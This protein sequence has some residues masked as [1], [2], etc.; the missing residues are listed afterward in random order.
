MIDLLIKATYVVE[1]AGL[2]GIPLGLYLL[3]KSGPEHP[4]TR[5]RR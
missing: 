3:I 5:E 2:I 1:G 4:R